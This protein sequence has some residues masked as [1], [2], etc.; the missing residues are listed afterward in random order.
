[1]NLEKCKFI[2]LAFDLKINEYWG[3]SDSGLLFETCKI[4]KENWYSFVDHNND[5]SPYF[6]Q[7]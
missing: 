5:F 7:I 1:M 3:I 2:Y 6:C 4:L